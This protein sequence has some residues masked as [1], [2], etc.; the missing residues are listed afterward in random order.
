MAVSRDITCTTPPWLDVVA[1]PAVVVVV[2]VELAYPGS[3][4]A[5]VAAAVAGVIL[6]LRMLGWQTLKTFYDPLVWILHAAYLWLPVGYLL[7]AGA[8]LGGWIDSSSALHALTAGAIGSMILA[9]G[10]RAALGHS[11]RPLKV[12]PATIVVYVLVL[13]AGL[14]RV[15]APLEGATMVSGLLWTAGYGLFC[16]DYW[17]ILTKPRIDGLPG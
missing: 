16:I 11:G 14:V 2:G 8:D 1:V 12:R 4:A 13:T 6:L 5:G 10:S 7:K 17:A 15:F 9:V 3:P